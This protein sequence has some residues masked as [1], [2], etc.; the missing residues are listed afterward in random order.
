MVMV[1]P[2]LLLLGTHPDFKLR[3]EALRKV[4]DRRIFAA[5][6]FKQMQIDNIKGLYDY[7]V[8]EAE[9]A[10]KVGVEEKEE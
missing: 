8:L 9:A 4:K 5:D 7:E 2:R 1:A 6:R 3:E 10:F